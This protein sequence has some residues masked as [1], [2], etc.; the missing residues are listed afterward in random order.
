MTMENESTRTPTTAAVHDAYRL[1]W[2]SIVAGALIAAAI[3]SILV[4]FGAAVGLG[5]SSASPTWRDASVALWLLSGVFLILQSL[6]SFGCG[7]Y[8]AARARSPSPYG[9]MATE[10]TERRD[11]LHGVTSWA[12]AVLIGLVVAASISLAAGRSTTLTAPPSSTEP[13]ALSYE[14]DQLFRSPRR[15]PPPDIAPLRSEAG[16]ILLTSSSHQG[17]SPDDRTYLAQLVAGVTGLAAADAD[18]RVDTIVS[19]SKRAL[20]HARAAGIILAFSVA[21][22][23]LLGAVAAWAGAEAGGHHRDGMPLPE[24]MLRSNRLSGRRISWARPK[25]PLS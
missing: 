20:S 2:T 22:A 24:W 21:T 1:D 8:L 12:L 7:G 25:A 9:S 5:V 6:V 10:E 13:S 14:I 3:A 19:E 23:L 18:R 11:G 16:R 15:L 4:T 17:V